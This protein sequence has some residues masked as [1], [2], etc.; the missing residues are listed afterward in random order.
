MFADVSAQV[1]LP[2]F[3]QFLLNTDVDHQCSAFL[4]ADEAM[5]LH[6]IFHYPR[7]VLIDIEN[8][9]VVTI[10]TPTWLFNEESFIV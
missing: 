7:Y 5:I 4:L 6:L 3:L 9:N 2:N 1:Q 10:Y 8:I